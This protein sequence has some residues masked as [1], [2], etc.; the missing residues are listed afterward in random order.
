M[1]WTQKIELKR[2]APDISFGNI[3]S[4]ADTQINEIVLY[5]RGGK[6]P[7]TVGNELGAY[8]VDRIID[9]TVVYRDRLGDSLLF[10]RESL[11][12]D[13]DPPPSNAV[14]M[15]GPGAYARAFAIY[16][17][18]KVAFSKAWEEDESRGENWP[19]DSF[20][21]VGDGSYE[22]LNG[23]VVDTN[24]FV[25][26]TEATWAFTGRGPDTFLPVRI[27]GS[28]G[29]AAR[30]ALA[31]GDG[32]VFFLSQDG[33]YS[34][35]GITQ[36]KLT[37]HIN[38][39][40]QGRTVDGSAG[41]STAHMANCRM[42]WYPHPDSPS[43]ILIYQEVTTLLWKMLIM[44]R[45]TQTSQ[46]TDAFFDFSSAFQ[47][48]ASYVDAETNELLA[49]TLTSHVIK[50]EDETVESDDGNAMTVLWRSPAFTQGSVR[51]QKTYTDV[52]IEANT[53]GQNVTVTG[54]L[55]KGST[56][57]ALGTMNTSTAIAQT[58]SNAVALQDSRDI[59]V[60]CQ[61]SVTAHMDFFGYGWHYLVEPETLTRLD[62]EDVS[63]PTIHQL[64]KIT[65]DMDASAAVDI[66][67]YLDG[68]SPTSD[69]Q[70]ITA[71][72]RTVY[73]LEYD[74]PVLRSKLFRVGLT[75]SA[76]FQVYDLVGWWAPE[77]ED[78]AVWD[79]DDITFPTINRLWKLN[80][81][82]SCLGTATVRVFLDGSATAA[83][84]ETITNNGATT[85]VRQVTPVEFPEDVL[86][87][88]QY[89][90]TITAAS[91]SALL[92]IYDV[93]GDFQAEPEDLLFWDSDD[94]TF[95]TITRLWNLN[96]D[97]SCAGSATIRVFVD[98]SSTAAFSDTIT[99]NG[100]GA[101]VRQVTLVELPDHVLRSK[102]YRVTI[103]AAS[104]SAL[105]QIYDVSGSF[106]AEPEDVAHWDSGRLTFDNVMA[107]KRLD[108]DV[109]APAAAE[110]TVLVGGTETTPV[111][112][113][114]ATSGRQR[115]N[116]PVRTG[117]KGHDL[118]IQADSASPLQLWGLIARLK[119]WGMTHGYKQQPV[120]TMEGSL[121]PRKVVIGASPA[122]ERQLSPRKV[123]LG[124]SAATNRQLAP[125]KLLAGVAA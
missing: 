45:N 85:G 111:Y 74:T 33:I 118:Q 125:R 32:Q 48:L 18:N 61:A 27:P 4:P 107:I 121:A 11:E 58:I 7:S 57:V 106:Q 29:L 110:I 37:A 47:A 92:Q 89:R 44:K 114:P 91:P 20:F 109:N 117:L 77:P 86:R 99:N 69:T 63:F 21:L 13:N 5:R 67:V 83:F 40:F 22:A 88:K 12:V 122:T 105:F 90:V 14:V 9:S 25:W 28:R 87:S 120:Q 115:V 3:L 68:E 119:A 1:L 65:L 70:V 15:F 71:G 75:S 6:L 2:H 50:L 96:V 17:R 97:W 30:Y 60:A 82:W 102:S 31:Y 62:T 26:T 59:A 116:V 80:V 81:D 72:D 112:Q 23:L 41:L 42:I 36:Q 93:N 123:V 10:T 84:S 66:N 101:G 39:F 113:L 73:T 38:P 34:Q 79:S 46:Y 19:Q 94:V 55:D 49:L 51:N 43:L 53:G 76:S 103:T 124:T 16:D 98:G 54:W 52:I 8:M 35:R 108:F 64:W 95:P 104:E 100:V 56:S 78:I 24:G